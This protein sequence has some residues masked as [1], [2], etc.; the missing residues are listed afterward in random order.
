MIHMLKLLMPKF[1]IYFLIKLHGEIN[2]HTNME[3][4]H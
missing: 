4:K 3:N 2:P 1:K